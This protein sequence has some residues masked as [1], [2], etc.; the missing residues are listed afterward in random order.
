MFSFWKVKNEDPRYGNFLQRP[1]L[2]ESLFF[3]LLSYILPFSNS[4]FIKRFQR[5]QIPFFFFLMFSLIYWFGEFLRKVLNP[6]FRYW[7]SIWSTSLNFI[8]YV[9]GLLFKISSWF[10]NFWTLWNLLNLL[11]FNVFSLMFPVKLHILQYF[12]V[13]GI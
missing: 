11:A 1:R 7:F 8:T 2:H 13:L 4:V 9:F 5:L 3:Y 10:V 6:V 12:R